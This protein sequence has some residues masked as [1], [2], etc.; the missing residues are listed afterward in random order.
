MQAYQKVKDKLLEYKKNLSCNNCGLKDHRVIEFHHLKDKKYTV[1]RMPAKGY[2]WHTI[3][4]EIDKCIPL[5]CNCHRIIHFNE[6]TSSQTELRNSSS[7]F[8]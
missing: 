5:C 4:K 1:S 2:C 3:K 8:H 6:L 7:F